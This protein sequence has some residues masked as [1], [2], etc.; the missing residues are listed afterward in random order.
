MA[1]I[2]GHRY[3]TVREHMLQQYGDF[4]V[5]QLLRLLLSDAG[6]TL[7]IEKRLRFRADLSAAFPGSEFTQIKLLPA[8]SDTNEIDQQTV[9]ISTM[10]F[11]I[12][13]VIGPL[14]ETFT[15]WVRELSAARS[16]AMADFLDIFNQRANLLRYQM[17]QALTMALHNAPPA[18]T[19]MARCLA[20]LMGLAQPQLAAQ[21]PLPDRN[22]LGLAGL[23]A[24]RRKQATTLVH[25]LSLALGTKVS[26]VP[27]VGAWQAIDEQDRCALGRRNHRL[28]STSVVGR[29]VWDQQARLRLEIGVIDYPALCR[30]LPPPPSQRAAPASEWPAQSHQSGYGMLSGLVKLLVDR[31]ADCEI[32]L[33]VDSTSIPAT[34]LSQPARKK[35]FTTMR[36][37]QSA[38]LTSTRQHPEATR[39]VRY[40][41]PTCRSMGAA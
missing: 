30:L 29:R 24:N 21:I 28:G 1:S 38:W 26:L 25:I 4:N 34:T 3:R 13:S 37:G 5:F 15:E 20:S 14:P 19:E 22:W 40:L 32:V 17:K 41:I 11:C 16:T 18:Q 6:S 10:N 31:L 36:L 23:L 8:V 39:S 35:E 2:G 12:A 27:F 33:N 7:P 9:E